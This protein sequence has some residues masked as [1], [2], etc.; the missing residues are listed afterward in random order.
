MNKLI[1]L[2]LITHRLKTRFD[3]WAEENSGATAVEFALIATPFF[4]LIF[5][6]LEV[7]LI[8]IISTTAE[9]GLNN[10]SRS[11]RTGAFQNSPNATPAAFKAQVCSNLFSLIDCNAL[12]LDVRSFTNFNNAVLPNAIDPNTGEINS[13]AFAFQPGQPSEIVIVRVFYEYDLAT[14]FI[15][16][17]LANFPGGNSRL[18]QA[19]IAFQNEPFN[20]PDPS[21]PTG[22]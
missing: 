1:G 6:L 20:A 22:P 2:T 15:S 18:V 12:E 4:I 10:A 19:T 21:T 11:I 3:A 5:G 16:R 14:P 7:A 8:F 17:P 9:F 13:G